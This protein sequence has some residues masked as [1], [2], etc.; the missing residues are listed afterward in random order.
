[1]IDQTAKFGEWMIW[2]R[3]ACGLFILLSLLWRLMLSKYLHLFSDVRYDDHNMQVRQNYP[4]LKRKQS[5]VVKDHCPELTM[6]NILNPLNHFHPCYLIKHERL[7]NKTFQKLLNQSV[8]WFLI[9]IWM[10]PS[11]V[12]YHVIHAVAAQPLPVTLYGNWSVI[13]CSMPVLSNNDSYNMLKIYPDLISQPLLS[14]TKFLIVNKAP[15]RLI[16]RLWLWMQWREARMAA[17]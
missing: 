15:T 16:N 14:D 12:W 8:S 11:C 7:K 2:R 5:K 13:L 4:T 17:S 3:R 6:E 9:L 1:M 10:L